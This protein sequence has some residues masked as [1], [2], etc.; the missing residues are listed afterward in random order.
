MAN[1]GGNF[2]SAS[3]EKPSLHYAIWSSHIATW[4]IAYRGVL[5]HCQVGATH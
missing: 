1:P 2:M 4:R 3:G 5:Q